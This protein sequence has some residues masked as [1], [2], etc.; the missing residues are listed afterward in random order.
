MLVPIVVMADV[1]KEDSVAEELDRGQDRARGRSGNH[2]RLLPA[3]SVN[4][5]VGILLKNSKVRGHS[6]C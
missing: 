2:H 5:G 1:L 6:Y 3:A 4:V